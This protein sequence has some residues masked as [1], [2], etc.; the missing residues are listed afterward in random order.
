MK[1]SDPADA[2]LVA[3]ALQRALIY[4]LLASAFLGPSEARLCELALGAATAAA[5]A[6]GPLR[7]RLARL[8]LAASEVEPA[9]AAAEHAYLF[10]REECCAPWESAYD[11]LAPLGEASA[12]LADVAGFYETFG[13]RPA[14]ARPG[15]EDHIAAELEFVSGLAFRE[16]CALADDEPDTHAVTRGVERAFL[17]EHLG[18]WAEAFAASVVGATPEPFHAAAASLL[19]AW[20]ATEIEALGAVPERV[21]LPEE[22]ER[23]CPAA[24]YALSPSSNQANAFR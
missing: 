23:V 19:G 22:A 12:R 14:A 13:P 1:F 7:E 8:A 17:G 11:D 2:A 16:A 3:E 15:A 24:A 10:G 18:R 5:A 9:A 4:R 20:V 6:R 21:L